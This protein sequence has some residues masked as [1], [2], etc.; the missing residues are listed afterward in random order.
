[1]NSH[2]RLLLISFTTVKICGTPLFGSKGIVYNQTE[3][4]VGHQLKYTCPRGYFYQGD[5]YDVCL[6]EETWS[7]VNGA[8]CVGKAYFPLA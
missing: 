2:L 3:F 5:E 6:E 7:S 1:M 8:E 4:N